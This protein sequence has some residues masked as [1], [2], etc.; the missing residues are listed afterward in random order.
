MTPDPLLVGLDEA[1]RHAVTTPSRAVVVRA[2]AG[3]GKTRVLTRRIAHRAGRGDLDPMHTLCV[4]FTRPAAA[5]LRRRLTRLGLRDLPAAGTFHAV[6]W[7]MLRT[8][9]HDRRIP[10]PTLLTDRRT[11][12][13]RLVDRDDRPRLGRISAEIDWARAND[14][15][16]AAYA[17]AA[18]AAG[19]RPGVA[20]RTVR[21]A[22]EAVEAAKR[23]SG[24]VDY[25]DLLARCATAFEDDPTF[26]AA[27]RW[28]HRHLH[29]DEF[30]D[31][32]PLQFR[33]LR[34]WVG[35]GDDLFVVGDPNQAI[36]GWN[37]ADPRLMDRVG[38]LVGALE[39][40]ELPTNHRS[41][42]EI[43]RVSAAAL[44]GGDAP[45][46][47][48]RPAPGREA[49]P[50]PT[51]IA[52]DDA[53][54]EGAAVLRTLRRWHDVGTPW[55]SLAVLARTRAAAAALATALR[56]G[57]VP[58]AAADDD[59]DDPT[60]G[61][62][63]DGTW[64]DLGDA[65]RALAPARRT[66]V[67]TAL[68][69]YAALEQRPS[70][71][72]FAAWWRALPPAERPGVDLGGATTTPWRGV[73]V[74]TF[75]AAKGREWHGVVVAGLD[76]AERSPLRVVGAD[77]DEEQRL[78]YVA[79][80]RATDLL[81]C[82]WVLE[83]NRGDGPQARRRSPYLEAVV[84]TCRTLQATARPAPPPAAVRAALP[85]RRSATGNDPEPGTDTD[86]EAS[87]RRVA[88]AAWRD[89]RARAAAVEPGTVLDDAALEALAVDPPVDLD[90][91]ARRAEVG[92]L[93]AARLGPSL[94]EAL[95]AVPGTLRPVPPRP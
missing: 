18:S 83:R 35:D 58:V 10:A 16:P 20:A 84:A 59:R 88:L 91:L 90:D 76:V 24:L 52:C 31:V 8:H 63:T 61:L 54:D 33:L 43:V 51:V 5:E 37:G 29:V 56:A 38:E 2:A 25:D 55:T 48:P 70:A 13:A 1:Q 62:P 67:E 4:T 44:I 75:H 94:L 93:R 78:C 85:P 6:A 22:F 82:T 12:L 41:S 89:G 34:A 73:T 79:L 92:P 77:R 46:S 14:L 40:V 86:A 19:R 27:Q 47:L 72:G 32:N 9:W 57:G 66:V 60:V 39:V 87:R 50:L 74:A 69:E 71:E 45:R 64:A 53:A 95:A 11:L 21:T 7:A 3:A 36:Y 23:S 49:G 68:A 26:A 30:Q 17:A 80:S 28:R 65:V 15:T 81:A 42:P